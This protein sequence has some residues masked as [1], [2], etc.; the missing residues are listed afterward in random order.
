MTD[1]D[2]TIEAFAKTTATIFAVLDQTGIVAADH[3]ADHLTILSETADTPIAA[4]ILRGIATSLRNPPPGPALR[5][6]VSNDPPE[7]P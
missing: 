4:S 2:G 5:L 7:R 1:L 6:V 3:I